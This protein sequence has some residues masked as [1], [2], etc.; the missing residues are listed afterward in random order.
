MGFN[1]MK[2]ENLIKISILIPAYNASN[3]I[4]RCL[5]SIV[6]QTPSNI[7]VMIIDDGS[8]DDTLNRIKT[9]AD[10]YDYI[11]VFVQDNSGVAITRNNLIKEA[12]GEYIH[13]LDAD[14][15]VESNALACISDVLNFNHSDILI[16]DYYS[17]NTRNE[18]KYIQDFLDVPGVYN[19]KDYIDIFVK[20][21][22]T[23][24][25]WNKLFKRSLIENVFFPNSI[26]LG[27][28]MCFLIKAIL[29]ADTIEK[30]NMA[31]VNYVDNPNGI[32][33]NNIAC[34]IYQL[35][36]V[37][38]EIT[39]RIEEQYPKSNVNHRLFD[40]KCH[41]VFQFFFLPPCTD[42]AEYLQSLS[43]ASSL[44]QEKL[45][46]K[47]IGF[48]R[49]KILVIKIMKLLPNEMSILMMCHFITFLVKTNKK[50]KKVL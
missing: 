19:S 46:A 17:I 9:F 34:K 35:K 30:C 14:D 15:W 21:K 13:F 6:E 23:T 5:N 40:I 28:D 3:T 50:L 41:H 31:L 16:A 4:T 39:E 20:E 1:I 24:A 26:T 7:E 25:V 37:F 18:K 11:K 32:T 22:G 48:K 27:E 47:F 45:P 10:T 36:Q 38:N 33:S 2:Q 42:R 49:W 44:L 12:K 29:K 8:T 43:Y